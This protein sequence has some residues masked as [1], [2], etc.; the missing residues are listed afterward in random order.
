[1][2]TDAKRDPVGLPVDDAYAA[3]VDAERLR[4][5]LRDHGLEPLSDRRAA[6]DDLDRA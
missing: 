5:D 3:V 6:G 1:M 2:G 4:A